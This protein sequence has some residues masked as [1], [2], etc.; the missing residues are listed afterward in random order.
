MNHPIDKPL[1]PMLAALI[2]RLDEARASGRREL[3]SAT[4]SVPVAH[5]TDPGH[6]QREQD[7]VFAHWPIVA[8]HSAELPPGSALPFDALGAPIVLTRAAEGR[9]R[10]FY[11]VCR[12]RGMALVAAGGCEPARAKP[13]KALVC[14][15]HAW[16]YELDGTLRGARIADLLTRVL[17]RGRMVTVV[18]TRGGWVNVNNLT[19]LIDAS[20]I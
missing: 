8:A 11:N 19:D 17:A 2:Q 1:P 12:H 4:G 6:W 9:V 14:P 15:Y 7:S 5:Y 10:A 20:G 18:Y 16:T 3:G 13:C